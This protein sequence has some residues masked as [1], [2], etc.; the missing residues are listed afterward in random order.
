MTS[1]LDP[2]ERRLFEALFRAHAARLHSVA[3]RGVNP[4]IAEQLVQDVFKDAMKQRD[5]LLLL[6]ADEQRAWL[7]HVLNLKIIDSFRLGAGK[8][9]RLF[10]DPDYSM[11]QRLARQSSTSRNAILREIVGKCWDVIKTMPE[12]RR[13]IFYL[14]A[15]Q[16]WTTRAIA[17][18]LGITPST[19]R[20]HLHLGRK[21]LEE[22]VG[23][24]A[25][26]FIDLEDDSEDGTQR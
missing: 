22:K 13:R 12:E 5:T 3:R 2:E 4:A 7:R 25:E 18:H 16:D 24:R 11:D 23:P 19:V 26:I 8:H 1:S 17:E 6:D 15:D 20:S 21:Q 10:R 14:R 9:E